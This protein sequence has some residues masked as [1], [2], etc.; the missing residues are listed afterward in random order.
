MERPEDQRPGSVATCGCLWK[1]L[2]ID[3]CLRFAWQFKTAQL[4]L[5]QRR[6]IDSYRF[7]FLGLREVFFRTYR[8]QL[9][10]SMGRARTR[11]PSLRGRKRVLLPDILAQSMQNPTASEL[12]TRPRMKAA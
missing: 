8:D 11:A 10:T 6:M 7:D 2:L 3:S 12:Y 1:C 4:L 9:T 5:A